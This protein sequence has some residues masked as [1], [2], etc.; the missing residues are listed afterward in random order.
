MEAER[1]VDG[2]DGQP[3]A[4]PG[5]WRPA[6]H[7]R[8]PLGGM[9]R[10]VAVSLVDNTGSLSMQGRESLSELAGRICVLAARAFD[11]VRGRLTVGILRRQVSQACMDRLSLF[12]TLAGG[13]DLWRLG[14]QGESASVCFPV[15]PLVVE[16]YRTGPDRFESTVT[17]LVSG[18]AVHVNE[19]HDRLGSRWLCTRLDM[20]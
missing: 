2:G 15:I 11:V 5:R 3:S 8:I 9:D 10:G 12:A 19:T 4:R 13:S 20:G 16:L 17:L 7:W 18:R 14:R 1:G 6:I